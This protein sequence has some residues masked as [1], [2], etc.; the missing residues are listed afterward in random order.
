[1]YIW[2][3]GAKCSFCPLAKWLIDVQLFQFL[4]QIIILLGQIMMLVTRT[5][6]T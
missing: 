4:V 6:K 5:Y 2:S 3:Q 1:M